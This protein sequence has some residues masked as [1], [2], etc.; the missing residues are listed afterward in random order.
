MCCGIDYR[1]SKTNT[2]L[3]RIRPI[4]LRMIYPKQGCDR[5]GGRGRAAAIGDRMELKRLY[6]AASCGWKRGMI[7]RNE[8]VDDE[9]GERATIHSLE[10][11]ILTP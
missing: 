9:L 7:W 2:A 4:I 10:A 6:E 1:H 8:G 5:L 11:V 3:A